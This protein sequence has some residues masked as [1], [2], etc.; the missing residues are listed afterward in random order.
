MDFNIDG[1]NI[2]GISIDNINIDTEIKRELIKEIDLGLRKVIKR[3]IK[4][5]KIRE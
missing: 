2:G 5:K 3:E 4:E 1:I